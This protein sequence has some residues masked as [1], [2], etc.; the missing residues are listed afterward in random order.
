MPTLT[1]RRPVKTLSGGETFQASLA[2]ALALSS[3]MAALAQ[4]G[5]ARL[6]SIFLDEGFG[7][8]DEATLEIVADTLETLAGQKERMVGV[9]THVPRSPNAS[10]SSSTSRRDAASSRVE[11]NGA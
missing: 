1:P 9:I 3:Q 7:T 6:D 2:L 5:A 4:A 8:L 10:R 11:R